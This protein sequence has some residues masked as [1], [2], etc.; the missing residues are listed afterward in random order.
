VKIGQFKVDGDFAKIA[1][2][3]INGYSAKLVAYDD[4]D[5][6]Y[7]A[8]DVP[9]EELFT[10]LRKHRDVAESCEVYE[11]AKQNQ[12]WIYSFGRR[13][14]EGRHYKFSFTCSARLNEIREIAR[15]EKQDKAV[16]KATKVP[17]KA[18]ADLATRKDII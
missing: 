1:T 5:Y 3:H 10:F 18:K 2:N 4:K 8:F 11:G 17:Q 12:T 14:I 13:L 6:L 15:R 16:A 7:K 9:V